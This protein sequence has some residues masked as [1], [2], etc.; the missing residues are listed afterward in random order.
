MRVGEELKWEWEFNPEY[1]V[2]SDLSS[3]N[4]HVGFWKGDDTEWNPPQPCRSCSCKGKEYEFPENWNGSFAFVHC[5]DSCEL[6]SME[7]IKFNFL[8]RILN[9]VKDLLSIEYEKQK[10]IETIATCD[11]ENGAMKK[12]VYKKGVYRT[13]REMGDAKMPVVIFDGDDWWLPGW[14]CPMEI[15]EYSGSFAIKEESIKEL[16]W[17]YPN[18]EDNS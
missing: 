5:G 18:P 14:E 4:L 15:K 3:G 10:K 11:I 12:K 6:Y 13:S 16:L 8:Q 1:E 17:E 7:D 9:K 2:F